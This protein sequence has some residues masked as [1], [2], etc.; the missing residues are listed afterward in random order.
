MI[1]LGTNVSGGDTVFNDRICIICVYDLVKRSHV[2][3]HL[4]RRCII[5]PFEKSFHEGLFWRGNR[6]VISFILHKSIFLHFYHK[7]DV[8]YSRYIDTEYQKNTMMEPV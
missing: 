4:H 1:T 5:G 2:L 7:G 6:D 3:K 8:F